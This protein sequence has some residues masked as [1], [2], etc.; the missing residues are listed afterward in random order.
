MRGWSA[1]VL[2][3]DAHVRVVHHVGRVSCCLES[4]QAQDQPGLTHVIAGRPGAPVPTE[5]QRLEFEWV[6]CEVDEEVCVPV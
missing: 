6:A 5:L 1:G 2:S 3:D 4:V